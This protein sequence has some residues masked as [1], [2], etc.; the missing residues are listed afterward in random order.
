MAE[1][2]TSRL[3]KSR[4]SPAMTAEIYIKQGTDQAGLKKCF[5]NSEIGELF[6]ILNYCTVKFKSFS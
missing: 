1:S 3:K 6:T 4:I 5:I 2:D